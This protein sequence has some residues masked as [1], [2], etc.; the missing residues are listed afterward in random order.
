MTE[1]IR[2]ADHKWMILNQMPDFQGFF[3]GYLEILKTNLQLVSGMWSDGKER[4]RFYAC[5]QEHDRR[6]PAWNP[7]QHLMRYCE[8]EQLDFYETKVMIEE[9]IG[10]RLKC[11]CELLRS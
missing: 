4:Y 6:N 7:F 8:R 3:R 9:R 1:N 10:R 11:E 5:G 2:T